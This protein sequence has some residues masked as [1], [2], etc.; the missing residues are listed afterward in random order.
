[1]F[2]CLHSPLQKLIVKRKFKKLI[3]RDN[4]FVL[5]ASVCSSAS[6]SFAQ[7]L[8]R[9]IWN[10]VW[11]LQSMNGFASPVVIKVE[12]V[13]VMFWE[14]C[15]RE[16]QEKYRRYIRFVC[17]NFYSSS[18]ECWIHYFLTFPINQNTVFEFSRINSRTIKNYSQS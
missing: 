15:F 9:T 8:N 2:F 7:A 17:W 11:V 12:I 4:R 14:F 5:A 3:L 10:S 13:S 18:L 16:P 6:H 1:M